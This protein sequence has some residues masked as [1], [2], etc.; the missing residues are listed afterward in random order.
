[1]SAVLPFDRVLLNIE[2][3]GHTSAFKA[4]DIHDLTRLLLTVS[5]HRISYPK[6]NADNRSKRKDSIP[7]L[8]NQE[9]CSLPLSFLLATS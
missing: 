4:F 3:L 1:M 2:Y 9:L 5:F 7:G 6:V 8:L